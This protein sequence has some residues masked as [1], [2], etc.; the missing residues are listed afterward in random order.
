MMIPV[1]DPQSSAAPVA[2]VRDEMETHRLP[3]DAH[4]MP[5]C[6]PFPEA[7]EMAMGLTQLVLQVGNPSDPDVTEEVEFLI[8][9]GAMHSIV[10]AAVLERLSIR[11]LSTQVF[12]LANGQRI[13]RRKG[14]A[15]FRYGDRVGIADVVFGE[16]GDATLL[17]V[18]TLESM[19]LGLDPVRRR[20][21][22]LTATL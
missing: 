18:T 22:P 9:S 7:M 16:E 6:A 3:V 17:G 1:E 21:L 10:P 8:D 11:P 15:V 2:P 5:A 4:A 12:V 14:G 20:L 19:E 13:S